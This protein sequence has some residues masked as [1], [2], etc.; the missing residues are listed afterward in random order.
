MRDESEAHERFS[1]DVD[2]ILDRAGIAEHDAL[3]SDYG[4][5]L[6]L[7]R[8][9]AQ[10]ELATDRAEQSVL[11]RRLIAIGEGSRTSRPAAIR[12]MRL[13]PRKLPRLALPVFA[14]LCILITSLVLPGTLTAATQS[15]ET[16]VQQV[17]LRRSVS[18]RFVAMP[19]AP[20]TGSDAL[21]REGSSPALV[22]FVTETRAVWQVDTPIGSFGG[23]VPPGKSPAIGHYASLNETNDATH[24]SLLVPGYLPQGYAFR[25]GL[26]APA[27][28]A[29]LLYDG[30]ESQIVLAQVR[31][32]EGQQAARQALREARESIAVARILATVTD[33]P[34]RMVPLED[35]LARWIE[36]HG[37]IWESEDMSLLVGGTH[38]DLDEATRIAISLSRVDRQR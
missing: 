5:M 36:G 27:D 28:A 9:L 33:K 24:N 18:I 11:R 3:P 32:A 25:E 29:Y 2:R 19:G 31:V 1:Q 34:V 17:V 14:L 37:L 13:I 7:A 21:A 30:P 16:M 35:D 15:F 22:T 38:L 20:L 4:A 8:R 26:V 10:T 23:S 6:A 12:D